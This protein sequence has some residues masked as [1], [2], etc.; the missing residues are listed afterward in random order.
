MLVTS[1]GMLAA[2]PE[3]PPALPGFHTPNTTLP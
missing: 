1:C 2:L 3:S